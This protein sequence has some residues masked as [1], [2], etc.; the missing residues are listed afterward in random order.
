MTQNILTLDNVT[1]RRHQTLLLRG[2]DLGV[3]ANEFVGVIGPNGAGKTTLLNVIAGFEKFTGELGLF[4]RR[5]TWKR[6]RRTRLRIGY[7]PQLF[8]IDP[9]FPIL[10][11]QAVMTGAAGRVGLFRTPGKK[12]EEEA[13]RLMDLMR[14]AHL[15][16]RPLGQLS[17]GERQKVS[18][19]RAILQKPDLLLLDE[20]N[21]NLDIAVQKEVLNL[22][23]E[24]SAREALTILFVTHDFNMLPSRM[25]RAVMLK[26][27][28]KVFDGDI[29]KALTG[30]TL[31]R[32]FQYPLETFER[33]GRRFVSYG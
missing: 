4:G 12:E 23:D 24:I 21:A 27:G 15:A 26:G 7:V 1:V 2:I 32:L 30:D 33:N 5:E 16:R 11:L 22:I 9:G 25:R 6:A 18:L 28:E 20:P 3:S 10:A 19:A 13:L 14:L 17:G 29:N 8:P 31:S